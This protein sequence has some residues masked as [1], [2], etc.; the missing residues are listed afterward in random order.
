[1][2][3]DTIC[4]YNS[5]NSHSLYCTLN[6]V[7]KSNVCFGDSGG[8]LVYY[9]NSKWYIY[10]ITSYVKTIGGKCS[11]TLPS[12]FVQ[13]P[14]YLNWIGYQLNFK[15]SAKSNQTVNCIIIVYSLIFLT[16]LKFFQ[17]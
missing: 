9:T 4:G 12:Y 17:Y 5:Y 11:N 3:G 6:S 14:V 7:D 10:G 8:S 15:S 2:N 16:I 1:M 13:V